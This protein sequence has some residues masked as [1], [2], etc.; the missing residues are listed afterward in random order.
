MHNLSGALAIRFLRGE[1]VERISTSL[2]K[3]LTPDEKELLKGDIHGGWWETSMM[4]LLR[5]DLVGDFKY[6]TTIKRGEKDPK[7]KRGYFGSPALASREFAEAS[8][9][10]MTE[11]GLGII[12][13]I[14]DG[15]GKKSDTVSELY[16]IY[17]LRPYSISHGIIILMT[18]I[19]LVL[20]AFLLFR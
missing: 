3:P 4:L 17:P 9:K 15:K 5:P 20:L 13:R 7:I 12:E 10:V 14:L 19:I 6:L 16:K 1:F 11:E 8:L 18:I 2:S